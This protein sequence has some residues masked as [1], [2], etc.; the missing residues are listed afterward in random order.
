MKFVALLIHARSYNLVRV[1]GTGYWSHH[2]VMN[3]KL[4]FN[5]RFI[6]R[7][8]QKDEQLRN[9]LTIE[10]FESNLRYFKKSFE[11]D[12]PGPSKLENFCRAAQHFISLGFSEAR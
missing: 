7:A 1:T 12:A 11:V 5:Y 8:K 2:N 9:S 6:N 3:F 10:T 4:Y